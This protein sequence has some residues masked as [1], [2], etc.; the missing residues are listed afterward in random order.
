MKKIFT[1]LVLLFIVNIL[2][3]Q[4]WKWSNPLPTGNITNDIHFID[5]STGYIIGEEG[6]ILKTIDGGLTW[7]SLNSGSSAALYGICFLD[8]NN[9]YVVGAGGTILKT[10][11]GGDTWTSS[12]ETYSDLM[13]VQFPSLNIGYL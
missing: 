11:D 12:Q 13:G 10:T 6:T 1:L 8:L 9:G 3:A 4:T 2:A 7:T 5:A